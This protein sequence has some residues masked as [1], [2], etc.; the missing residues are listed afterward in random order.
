MWFMRNSPRR[1]DRKVPG[2][3]IHKE[4][5]NAEVNAD[6][7]DVEQLRAELVKQLR[8]ELLDVERILAELVEVEQLLAERKTWKSKMTSTER[9]EAKF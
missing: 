4:K 8:A 6:P 5:G 9:E 7:L 2:L 3:S 1:A